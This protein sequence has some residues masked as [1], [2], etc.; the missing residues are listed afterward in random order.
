MEFE[1]AG[2]VLVRLQPY[3][4]M[5]LKQQGKN[6]LGPKF[7]GPYQIIRKISPVAYELKLP[8]KSRIHN[9]FHV[10]K[11]K[12]LLGQYQSGQT[13]LPTFD[14]EGKLVLEPEVIINIKERRLCS[15]TIKKYLIKWK[16]H[17]EEDTS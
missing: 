7:Y 8:D 1:V 17:I 2:W 12:N 10:S 11:L 13:T 5:S 3:N 15:R 14:E 9:V 16:N 6:K 4:Q